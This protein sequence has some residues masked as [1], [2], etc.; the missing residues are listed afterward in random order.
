M[1]RGKRGDWFRYLDGT[2]PGAC[3][4]TNIEGALKTEC[5]FTFKNNFF[6]K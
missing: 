5:D 6:G 2:R 1:T 4:M 3:D